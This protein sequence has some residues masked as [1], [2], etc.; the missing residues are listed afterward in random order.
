MR[1]KHALLIHLLPLLI[2]AGAVLLCSQKLRVYPST[3]FGWYPYD[4]SGSGGNSVIH[5]D[6]TDANGISLSYSIGDK[7]DV[8]FIGICFRPYGNT[9]LAGWND[10]NLKIESDNVESLRIYLKA[11]APGFSND[12]ETL[13]HVHYQGY[14]SLIRGKKV[15]RIA[16]KD[17]S[18]PGWWYAMWEREAFNRPDQLLKNNFVML[19]LQNKS[20]PH[21][22][23]GSL[24]IRE[25]YFT[26][27]RLLIITLS[28]LMILCWYAAHKMLRFLSVKAFTKVEFLGETALKP[29]QRQADILSP[30][31]AYIGEHYSDPDISL[32]AVC[33][34]CRCSPSWLSTRLKQH[35]GFSFPRYVN[36]IRIHEAERLFRTTAMNVSEIAYAT[37][38]S[39]RTSFSRVFSE[40]TGT[41]PRDFRRETA[42]EQL[43]RYYITTHRS[44]R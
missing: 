40:I 8:P 27:N 5:A 18:I 32:S 21:N 39:D 30:M 20:G 4:D 36:L 16:L 13:T 29:R 3:R 9:S 43:N 22:N 7:N 14:I 2:L 6:G 41:S 12:T 15:R 31:I 42:Q 19:D 44:V 10:L 34:N 38:Y 23:A 11:F 35:Y 26:R 24:V 1:I 28:G 17:F 37:G 25:I 33:A